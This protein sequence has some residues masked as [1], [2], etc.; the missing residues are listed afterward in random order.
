MYDQYDPFRG[1]KILRHTKQYTT[2]CT[3]YLFLPVP[4][5]VIQRGRPDWP[6]GLLI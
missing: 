2:S 6:I 5:L 4:A 3:S 1:S